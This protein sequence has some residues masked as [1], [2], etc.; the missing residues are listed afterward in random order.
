MQ[1]VEV[2]LTLRTCVEDENVGTKD[3]IMD[4]NKI[5]RSLP[6]CRSKGACQEVGVEKLGLLASLTTK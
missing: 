1:M 3:H 2:N 6:L 4:I 5:T